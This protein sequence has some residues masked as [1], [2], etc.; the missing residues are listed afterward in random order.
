MGQKIN[1]TAEGWF[2]TQKERNGYYLYFFGQNTIYLLVSTFLTT[3]LMFQGVDLT[4]S[5]TVMLAVKVWD[6][7]NDAIFGVIFDSVKFKS[8]K[9][10]LPWL[11]ISTILIPISTVILFA[12]PNSAGETTK[13][14]WFAVAYII[15]DAAYTLCDVPIYGA[16]TSI[17]SNINERNH[18]LSVK[19]IWGG[20]GSAVTMII[21]TLFVGEIINTNYTVVAVIIAVIAAGTM[22]PILFRLK[23]RFHT[24]SEEEFSIKSMLVYLIKNKYL[25]IY[26]LGYFFSSAANV[27]ASL[28]LFVSYYLF[29][30]SAFSLVVS[31]IGLLPSLIFAVITP[32]IL[33]K[34][35]KMKVYVICNILNV[36]LSVIIYFVGYRSVAAFIILSTVRAVPAAI[37]GILVFMFT[38]DCAEYGKFKSGTDAIGITFSIQTFMTKLTG[39]VSGALG[40]FFLGLKSTGWITVN[41]ENFQQLSELGV[42]QS[43]HALGM[44]WFVYSLLPAIGIIIALV[45]WRF[46]KL[47]DKDVQIMADCNAG[48]T[49]KEEAAQLLSRTY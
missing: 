49:T 28:N 42:V 39:A 21:A 40:L 30:N 17:T 31:A 7:V 5:A 23:E 18:M 24:E 8:K 14:V 48:K 37:S 3:Y 34:V 26:Y 9:K 38:P 47:N 16:I 43:P 6:A 10:Y 22:A 20:A 12:I 27:S 33:N 29:N 15:W 13:L 41:V 11:K 46:Y 45:V 25:L 36:I 44:L 4:K 35:D 2:T 19:S 1:K 32:K